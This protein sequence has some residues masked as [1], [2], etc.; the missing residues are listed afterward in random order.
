MS[1]IRRSMITTSGRRRSA[2]ATADA[3]SGGLADHADPRRAG[4]R[5]AESFADDLVVVRDETGD[6]V[7]HGA[8]LRRAPG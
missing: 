4:E 6:L 7:G 3:P 2:S 5:E 8:I 1:G